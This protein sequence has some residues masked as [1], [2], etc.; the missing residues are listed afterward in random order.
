MV[1]FGVEIEADKKVIEVIEEF[2]QR[3]QGAGQNPA[4]VFFDGKATLLINKR[5]QYIFFNVRINPFEP[6]FYKKIFFFMFKKT[7]KK[8]GYEQKKPKLLNN[9]ELSRLLEG[10]I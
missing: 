8:K 4:L 3:L 10:Y 1:F 6:L 9:K 2:N 5:K 7:L